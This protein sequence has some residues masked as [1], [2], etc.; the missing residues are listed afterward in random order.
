[1]PAG[2]RWKLCLFGLITTGVLAGFV[3]CSASGDPAREQ[4]QAA[5]PE[6]VNLADESD[7]T[8]GPSETP[9]DSD[10]PLPPTASIAEEAP[11]GVAEPAPFVAE[12]QSSPVMSQMPP[13][14]LTD[15][16]SPAAAMEPSGSASPP[17]APE[18]EQPTTPAVVEKP[19]VAE[20]A[21]D[22]SANPL[23]QPQQP[24][25]D[26]L[27]SRGTSVTGGGT[28]T[29]RE[30][31][32]AKKTFGK[33][34]HSGIPFDPIKE[35][36]T[37]FDGWDKPQLTLV[38]TGRQDGYLEPCGCAGLD[39]TKGGLSRRHSLFEQLRQQGWPVV[40]L[41]VGGLIKGFGRQAEL[42]FHTTVEAMRKMDY[43]VIAFGKNDLQLPA[44]ELVAVAASV[45]GQQSPFVAANVG[46]FGFDSGMTSQS[47]IVDVGGQKLGITAVLGQKY[48]QEINNAEVAMASP[49]E[50][51]AKIVPTLKQKADLLI[52][53]AHAPKEESIELAR[54]FPDFGIVITSGGPPDPPREKTYVEGSET[55][56]VEVGEKGMN[57]VVL[58]FFD[59]PKDPVRYQRVRLDARFPN[60]PDMKLLM[61]AYQDQLKMLG[62]AG[63]GIR[64]VPHPQKELNGEY[65]GSE[66]CRDC[67]K[68]SHE[69]WKKSGH[70]RAW[71]TLVELDPPRDFD[72]ECISCHVVGWDPQRY[73]P[74]ESGFLN[75]TD[76]PHL[77]DVGCESCHGPG[78]AHVDAELEEKGEDLRKKLQQA[79]VI[80]KEES[81]KWQCVTCHDLDNSPDFDFEEYWPQVEHYEEKDGESKK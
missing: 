56:L 41:D 66:E 54:Q 69:I 25:P 59:D 50:T 12:S 67:H 23:R 78:M 55:L 28:A 5:T 8:A 71:Q 61:T 80:T 62:F 52:L 16:S 4:T 60:S 77:V 49:S 39:R 70:A 29:E 53:L 73:F 57:A 43:D 32:P 33:G 58:G 30:T 48:Q 6:P 21:H 46:L 81:E 47:R 14:P 27:A 34:K 38:I 65:A 36:G 10:V 45:D 68:T 1:M 79:M 7:G 2:L 9:A 13:A 76:T 17:A 24:S 35:H 15:S 40:G 75:E 18:A 51:L 72:P 44:A 64:E 42:K 19:T 3:G 11:A 31:V 63:L 37:Y 22:F 74:Y 20:S 26:L